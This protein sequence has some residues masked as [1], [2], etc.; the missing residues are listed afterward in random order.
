MLNDF[1]L[2]APSAA[3]IAALEA[4][5][6]TEARRGTAGGIAIERLAPE[7]L[8]AAGQQRLI[9][10]T[11][12]DTA[13]PNLYALL[14]AAVTGD[15]RGKAGVAA[16]LGV[17][18][19]YVSQILSTGRSAR[20][21]SPEFVRRVLTRYHV[22]VCPARGWQETP[23]ADCIKANGPAPTHNPL[24][25]RIWRECQRCPNRPAKPAREVTP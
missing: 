22:V 13:A 10:D 11:G 14:Q 5:R 24:A 6:G 18:R 1:H 3:D 20:A 21:P 2:T 4:A 19:G 9:G 23:Y 17:S 16:R 15:K 7:Q 12:N 25:M 8:E